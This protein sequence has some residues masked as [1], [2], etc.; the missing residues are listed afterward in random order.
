MTILQNYEGFARGM[1]EFES[2]NKREPHKEKESALIDSPSNFV[3]V[4]KMVRGE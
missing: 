3:F 2:A 4:C 1:P